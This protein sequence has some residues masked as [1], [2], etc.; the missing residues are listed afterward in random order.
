[1]KNMRT[2][3]TTILVGLASLA[4][5]SFAAAQKY[6]PGA[7]ATEI[8][9]GNTMPQSGPAAALG[10]SLKPIAAYFKKVNAEGGVNGRRINFISYD[11]G[12]NP[13]K[14]VELTRRLVE[15]DKVLLIFASVGT[16]QNAA[17]QNY[18]NS[19]KV[20]HLFV[21]SGASRW[22][23]PANF[24]WTMGFFPNYQT[25][26][27]IYAQYL[28][29]AH[30]DGKIAALYQNDDYGRDFLKGLKDGLRDKLPV[31]AEAS[32]QLADTSLNAQIGTL[33]ASGADILVD[34]STARFTVMAIRRMAEIGWKPVHVVNNIS[35]PYI[36]IPGLGNLEGTLSGAYT[37]DPVVGEWKDDPGMQE[38]RAF[39]DK[40]YPE[41]TRAA[42]LTPMAT[43]SRKQWCK[44]SS[45]AVTILRVRT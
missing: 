2:A 27:R 29:Q 40:Y 45:N 34:A 6:D 44:S 19:N 36:S 41:G 1:M 23:D 31:I 7:S 14:T 32:Y 8:R 16:A 15:E 20:P 5:A 17:I 38:Y 22:D 10:A 3:L 28:M 37:K 11:D 26:A 33:K 13:A 9:I 21:Q 43:R 42:L 18:L 24:P 35:V 25:E 39:M 4:T 30:P 12:Y